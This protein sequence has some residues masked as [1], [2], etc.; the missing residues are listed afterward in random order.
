MHRW[1]YWYTLFATILNRN[2]HE[3]YLA[4]SSLW[5]KKQYL[6][7]VKFLVLKKAAMFIGINY[8]NKSYFIVSVVSFSFQTMKYNFAQY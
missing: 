2:D 5:Q 1:K 3:Y 8:V 6:S 4:W 7:F